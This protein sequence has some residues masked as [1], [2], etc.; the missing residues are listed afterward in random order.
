VKGTDEVLEDLHNILFRRK[1]K[2]STRKRDIKKF[3]GYAYP[4]ES[5]VRDPA[6]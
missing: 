4:K 5:E 2:A 6:P 3:S 1:G